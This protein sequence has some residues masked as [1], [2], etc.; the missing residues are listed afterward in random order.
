MVYKHEG[1][2]Q[3]MD[4]ARDLNILRIYGWNDQALWKA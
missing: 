2:R 4:T 3:C 1:F